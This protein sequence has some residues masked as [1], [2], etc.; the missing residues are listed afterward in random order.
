MIDILLI[1]PFP[2]DA[3]GI[4]DTTIEPPIG[5]GYLGAVIEKEGLSVKILD[6]NVLQM[7]NNEVVKV[8]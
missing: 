5:L 1:N 7:L 3:V 6:A 8:V 4:N 2:S